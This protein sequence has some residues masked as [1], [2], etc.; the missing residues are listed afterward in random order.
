MDELEIAESDA[1]L[2]LYHAQRI[3][4]LWDKPV[5][6]DEEI[7]QAIGLPPSTWAQVKARCQGPPMFKLGRRVFVRTADLIAW[8]EA[9]ATIDAC[10]GHQTAQHHAS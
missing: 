1:R 10:A 6:P 4:A 9:R 5:L 7:P 2:A 8:L 3:S